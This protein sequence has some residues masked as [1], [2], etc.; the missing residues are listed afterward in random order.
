V[1]NNVGASRTATA[2]SYVY[3]LLIGAGTC[4]Y[5][6]FFKF[7]NLVIHEFL[8]VL[9]LLWC[10]GNALWGASVVY[11]A[12]AH[13]DKSY[14]NNR[15]DACRVYVKHR[16]RMLDAF[17]H[18]R[19]KIALSRKH[20]SAG[21]SWASK[22]ASF[23]DNNGGEGEGKD[24]AAASAA[25]RQEPEA[26]GKELLLHGGTSLNKKDWKQLDSFGAQC[27]AAWFPTTEVMR[28]AD[29]VYELPPIIISMIIFGMILLV[30]F[31]ITIQGIADSAYEWVGSEILTFSEMQLA[32]EE[33]TP[34]A[35]LADT[36]AKLLAFAEGRVAFYEELQRPLYQSLL[37]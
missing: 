25:D 23:D 33:V 26:V 16:V 20:P 18:N 30:I 11:W 36:I 5:F 24:A 31:A 22:S 35:E 28:A 6:W 1:L 12:F 2:L 34:P 17:G 29:V 4:A 9:N 14:Y 13:P 7:D 32:L 15:L 10:A 21:L 19:L 8:L 3:Y 27:K 37:A